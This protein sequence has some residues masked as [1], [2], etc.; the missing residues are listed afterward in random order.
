MG[1]KIRKTLDFRKSEYIS[2]KN[3]IVNSKSV[4]SK[5]SEYNFV[6]RTQTPLYTFTKI[7]SFFDFF[8]LYR[9]LEI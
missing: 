2:F 6:Q 9:I 8:P 1:E 3:L 4:T 7:Q 5:T